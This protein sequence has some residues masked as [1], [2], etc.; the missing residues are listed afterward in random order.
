MPNERCGDHRSVSQPVPLYLLT[1]ESL[2]PAEK[3]YTWL[4]SL[5]MCHVVESCQMLC[6]TTLVFINGLLQHVTFWDWLPSLNQCLRDSPTFFCCFFP[7]NI[8]LL[9][10][11]H[12]FLVVAHGIFSLVSACGIWFPDQ[13]WNP[14]PLRWEC[15]ALAPGPTGKSPKLTPVFT[16]I[17]HLFLF[18]AESWSVQPR[19]LNSSQ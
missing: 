11:S 3:K 9:M 17:H 6:V 4:S 8:Y 1:L 14:R 7:F 13:G 16:R 19:I 15:R 2:L 12:W 10:W 18:P 5:L